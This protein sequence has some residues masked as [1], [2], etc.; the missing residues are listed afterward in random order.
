MSLV[1]VVRN[2][3]VVLQPETNLP[4]GTKVSIRLADSDANSRRLLVEVP[5]DK[6]SIARKTRHGSL[7]HG[8]VACVVW[9]KPSSL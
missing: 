4:E 1:G 8:A 7:V 2:G 3:V 9:I 5:F 6:C